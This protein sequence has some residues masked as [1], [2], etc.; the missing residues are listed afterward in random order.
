MIQWAF[1]GAGLTA[2][3]ALYQFTAVRFGLPTILPYEGIAQGL[4]RT[5][6]LS[7]EPAFLAMYLLSLTPLIIARMMRSQGHAL[8]RPGTPLLLLILFG[9]LL[10]NSRAGYLVLV[11]AVIIP[12]FMGRPKERG[13]AIRAL[14]LVLMAVGVLSFATGFDS[15]RFTRERLASIGDRTEAASN[16]PRLR[17][18]RTELDI[19]RDNLWLGIGPGSL[20]YKLPEYGLPLSEYQ[21]IPGPPVP[22]WRVVANNI[23]LQML[24]DGGV[25]ALAGMVWVICGLLGF[26][27][28][29]SDPD[30]RWIA[31]GCLLVLLVGGMLTSIFWDVKLWALIGLCVGAAIGED[32]AEGRV[33]RASPLAVGS[34]AGQRLA[35]TR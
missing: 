30:A 12:I 15:L 20:S 22:R 7:Y 33:S 10:A 9:I 14:A 17:A 5:A 16:G 24:L 25:V 21:L 2:T 11:P 1:I 31:M 34:G 32:S 29:S 8:R 19:V 13:T 26:A 27:R 6:G 18:Y 3:I 35:T 4:G 28:R 23:W